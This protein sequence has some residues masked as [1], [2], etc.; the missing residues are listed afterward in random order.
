MAEIIIPNMQ[1]FGMLT[2]QVTS[3]MVSLQSMLPRLEAAI[4]TASSGYQGTAGTEFEGPNNN[5]GV[6]AS[7]TPGEQG[8]AYAYA[9][10]QLVTA[11]GQFVNIAQP[12]IT[13]LDNG[14]RLP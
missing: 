12:Y 5:F 9:V 10:G 7:D 4:A 2:N 3:A 11:W 6:K 13:A 8:Q 1:P 14:Y